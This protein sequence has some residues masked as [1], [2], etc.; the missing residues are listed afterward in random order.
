LYKGDVEKTILKF[1]KES[2]HALVSLL[3]LD[4]DIYKPT[5][6]VLKRIIKRMPKGAIILFGELST[7]LYPGETRALLETLDIQ[8]KSIKR[9]PFST[10][11]S[12]LII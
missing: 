6:F 10:T 4:V 2:P 5:K 8:K 3:H 7:K 11:M 12:Y 1:E 9:F